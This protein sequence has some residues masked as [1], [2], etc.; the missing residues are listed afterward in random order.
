MSPRKRNPS[1]FPRKNKNR[2]TLHSSSMDQNSIALSRHNRNRCP[3]SRKNKNKKI[4]VSHET[5]DLSMTIGL[6]IGEKK[7]K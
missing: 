3:F 4:K 1:P 2:K 5:R 6:T 7:N